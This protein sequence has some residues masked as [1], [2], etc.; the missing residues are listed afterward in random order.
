MISSQCQFNK[1]QKFALIS[2]N[3][4][5]LL[6]KKIFCLTSLVKTN[7]CYNNLKRNLA[8][9]LLKAGENTFHIQTYSRHLPKPKVQVQRQVA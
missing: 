9:F 4:S 6:V 7:Y 1:T 2:L 8:H 3:W 5:S